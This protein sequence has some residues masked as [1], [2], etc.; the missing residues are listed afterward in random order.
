VIQVPAIVA[1]GE[2]RA[3]KAVYGQPKVYLEVG[4]RALVAHVVATLQRVPEVS[5]VW[6]VGN[7]ARLEEV[8]GEP[9]LQAE[10]R[11]PL[12]VVQE[13][14]NLLEN[15]WQ[16]Y[17]RLLPGAGPQ[18]RDPGPE[19]EALPVLYLS[20]DLPLATPQEIS[21]FIRRSLEVECDYA[22]GLCTA[23][24][25]RP[26]AADGARPG[27][28]M[29][30]FNVADGRFRQ[31][32]LHLVRPARIG[33]RQVVEEMYE[34]RYQKQFG[35]VIALAWR[36]LRRDGGG[37]WVV[38]N[39]V[40]MVLAGWADRHGL[41]RLRDLLR[42]TVP[43]SRLEK[44]ISRLMGTRYRFVVTELGGCAA[45]VDNEAD[46]EACRLRYEEWTRQQRALAER[47]HGSL[48][49]PELAGGQAVQLRRLQDGRGAPAL[50]ADASS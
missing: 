46:L 13:F 7:A 2:G 18:G 1:A 42:G 40:V 24:S 23:E 25:L 41:R 20:G 9:A 47:L 5:E 4:G 8:L 11:K 35:N 22:L 49:L 16:T 27:M 21:C 39:Y 48:S 43:F 6:V 30:V 29:A 10:L 33:N 38:L 19:D 17:R 34:H 50:S 36:L 44:G 28:D 12:V 3:A 32:N 26:F 14:R 45:D 15:G 31:S 37:L